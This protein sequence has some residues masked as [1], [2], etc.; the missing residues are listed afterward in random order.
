VEDPR[1]QLIAE[2][3]RFVRVL[4]P[5]AVLMENVPGLLDYPGMACVVDALEQLGYPVRPATQVVDALG[6][7]VPQRRRRIVMMAAER[8][9]VPYPIPQDEVCTVRETIGHLPA[10]GASGDPAH[11]HG[12]RRT[13]KVQAIIAAIPKNGGSRRDLGD[14]RQ[15]KC[16]RDTDG[17]YDIYGRMC[18]DEPA[19]TITSGC[20]N[21]SKGRFLHPE[22]N[23]AITLREAALLQ[24]F[25]CEY[26]FDSRTSCRALLPTTPH[27]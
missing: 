4:R 24:G 12:E 27:I 10:A 9:A 21:P 18:W 11:D 17:F 13:K 26:W 1:N 3:V 5:K 16:H 25:P 2:Y 23:R 6:F 8:R 7:G 20:T 15:L 22:E 14:E 19:P